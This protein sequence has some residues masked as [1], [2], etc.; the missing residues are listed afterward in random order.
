[1]LSLISK[2]SLDA[3]IEF[4]AVFSSSAPVFGARRVC[5]V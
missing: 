2:P 4:S 5:M 1:V 3:L